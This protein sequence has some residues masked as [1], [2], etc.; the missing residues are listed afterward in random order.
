MHKNQK[1]CLE[2]L[3]LGHISYQHAL[4]F[5]KKRV[6]SRIDDVVVDSLLL[7]E[8]DPVIT[9]GLR[10]SED[11]VHADMRTLQDRGIDVV[12][13]RRGGMATFHGQGQ[14]VAYPIVRLVKQTVPQFV[15]ALLD[16]LEAVVNDFDIK[17]E[18][19]V[20]GYGL[21]AKGAKIAS[22]GL[23]LRK[24]TT[25][26]G[27]ALNINTDISY[28][29]LITPCGNPHE[30]ITSMQD[31]LK[32]TVD[33]ASVSE[34]FIHHFA[35]RFGYTLKEAQNNGTAPLRRPKWFALH[36]FNAKSIQPMQKMISEHHL[37]T[38]CQEAMCPN[39]AECF[40]HGTSTFII[41]GDVCTRKCRYCAVTKGK[42]N[43]LDDK[44]PDN[45]AQAVQ[46]LD[47][48]HAVITS[49]TRDDL[50]DGGAEHFVRT[51]Q[52]IRQ[53]KPETSIE[54]LVP[55]F[56]GNETAL[57][58]VCAAKPDMFN[59]N[60]ETVARLFPT[61]RP[62]ADYQT[63]L[64]VLQFAAH[65]GLRVKSGI[66]LGLG[67]TW[68]EVHQTIHE[69]YLHGCRFL[70]LGQYLAPSRNHAP[71]ARYVAPDEFAHWKEIALEKGFEGVASAPLVRSSYR[72]EAML[73]K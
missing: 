12:K 64:Q 65:H 58:Q 37:H 70:T 42:P 7:A 23:G 41:M 38:V 24:W 55:D 26:H 69:L 39:K 60:I 51:V 59:H 21:W 6:Q 72:A 54:I 8:H 71:I 35:N 73:E 18:R 4:S 40:A 63:S 33:Y 11:D 10:G 34:A 31:L 2:V 5:Q 68:D 62:I 66:M 9:L 49:V 22:V 46:T 28:F 29:D 50:A 20:H 14:L 48:K 17:T 47:L 56:Q 52:A 16:V 57:A 67:E 30:R 45:V 53:R 43:A 27:I 13:I 15:D 25:F 32:K 61:V 44:E 3:D 1:P 36:P 19:N